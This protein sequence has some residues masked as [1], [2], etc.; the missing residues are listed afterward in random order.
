MRSRL[1]ALLLLMLSLMLSFAVP[2]QAQSV[3]VTDV[4]V[5]IYYSL[6]DVCLSSAA[7]GWHFPVTLNKGED[8]V[9]S[10]NPGPGSNPGANFDTSEIGCY[11]SSDLASCDT[12]W[13]LV[14]I[15]FQNGEKLVFWDNNR[16]LTL[17]GHDP[18]Y[19]KNEAQ[20]FTLAYHA[21][22]VD[23][24][25]AYWDDEHPDPCGSYP[26]AMGMVGA[27]NCK[28]IGIDQARYVQETGVALEGVVQ[29]EPNHCLSGSR[30]CHDTGVIRIVAH[31]DVASCSVYGV[32]TPPAEHRTI[33]EFPDN[34]QGAHFLP[35]VLGPY[36]L[37]VAIPAGLYNITVT[38]GDKHNKVDE[39]NLPPQLGEKVVVWGL[40]GQ[41]LTVA[42][43]G[44]TSDVPDTMQA[45]DTATTVF[46]LVNVSRPIPTLYVTHGGPL[47]V[48]EPTNSVDVLSIE[49][50]CVDSPVRH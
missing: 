15:T 27:V 32:Y 38:T 12:G 11:R 3:V 24:F 37:P 33:A 40:D 17:G 41:M 19:P 6:D 34:Y 46:P 23:V 8:L 45:Y 29:T 28:P 49:W 43:V 21:K 35:S 9:L 2:V 22:N 16:V 14:T 13:A 10:Q 26:N 30:L 36:V 20:E 31:A 4:S 42:S 7:V 50:Q 44:P 47:H 39:Q 1:F 5:C 18:N 48:S 25:L